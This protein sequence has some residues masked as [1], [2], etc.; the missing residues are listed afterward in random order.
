MQVS[1]A[2]PVTSTTVPVNTTTTTKSKEQILIQ[3]S[4]AMIAIIVIGI[5]FI[6][7]I[8]LLILRTYNR[9]THASRVLGV[10]S[11]TRPRH[12]LSQSTGQSSMPLSTMGVHSVTNSIDN[13]NPASEISFQVPTVESNGIEG[14]HIEQFSTI[15]DSTVVTVHDTP[16][17]GNT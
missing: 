13:S 6:V 14:N 12:K 16:S 5:I 8:V 4:G 17:I 3:S 15:S 10:S 9:R 11:S 7:A 1:T 2:T